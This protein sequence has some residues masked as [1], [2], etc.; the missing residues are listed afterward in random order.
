[1]LS[2]DIRGESVSLV[3]DQHDGMNDRINTEFI[4][5]LN[6]LDSDPTHK[7]P[8]RVV[9]QNND[10]PD[11]YLLIC[12]V[13][14]IPSMGEIVAEVKSEYRLARVRVK[15]QDPEFLKS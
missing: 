1:M 6:Q 3:D 11:V 15:C 9:A 8:D 4:L 7:E 12:Y 10:S 5:E 14:Q 13:L 2:V